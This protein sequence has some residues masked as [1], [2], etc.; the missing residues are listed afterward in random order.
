[1]PDQ[2]KIKGKRTNEE[3]QGRELKGRKKEINKENKEGRKT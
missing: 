2:N 3:K 1:V